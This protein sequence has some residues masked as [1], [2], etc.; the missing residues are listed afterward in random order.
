MPGV[1]KIRLLL[2]IKFT[3]LLS[4][5]FYLLVPV[6]NPQ[7]ISFFLIEYWMKGEVDKK[8][9]ISALLEN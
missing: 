9:N 4:C 8:E 1:L 2:N 7:N 5:R 6:Q 3:C